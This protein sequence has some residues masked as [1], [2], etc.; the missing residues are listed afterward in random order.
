M[1][2]APAPLV[3]PEIRDPST[4]MTPRFNL[5]LRL[6]AR[7]FFGH[8]DIG[9]DDVAK[10]QKL[11]GAGAVV[12]VM[13][14]ASRLDYF[15]FNTLFAREGLRLSAFANGISFY[16]FQPLFGALRCALMRLGLRLGKGSKRAAERRRVREHARRVIAAGATMFLFLRPRRFSPLRR[17]RFAVEQGRGELDLLGEIVDAAGQSGQRVSLVPLALFWRRGPRSPARF[18]RQRYE[19]STRPSDLVKVITFLL[20]Y[21]R[22]AIKVG[23]PLEVAASNDPVGSEQQA[24]RL[25]RRMLLA[26]QDE[27]RSVEGPRLQPPSRVKQSVLSRARVRVAIAEDALQHGGSARANERAEKIFSEIAANMNPTFLALAGA[28]VGWVFRRLFVSIETRGLAD[29]RELVKRYPVVLVPSHRSYFDFLLVSWLLHRDYVPPP[30][31][32]AR[33]NM[34]FGPFGFLFRRA[35]AFFLRRSF[36]GELYKAVFRAYVGYLVEEGFPQEFFIEGGRSRTGKSRLPQ[37]GMLSWNIQG[38]VD[39]RRRE[40]YFVPISISY[41]RLVEEDALVSE[42][43]GGAKRDESML[44]LVRAR[45]LLK[46]RR[47]KVLVNFGEPLSLARELGGKRAL[48]DADQ[49]APARRAFVERFGNRIVERIN[50]AVVVNATSVAACALLGGAQRGFSRDEVLRRMSEVVEVLKLQD[51]R[52]TPTFEADVP[53][54][55]ESLDFLI[56]AGLLSKHAHPHGEVLHIGDAQWRTLDVHR[57][58]ILHYLAVPGWM[59]WRLQHFNSSNNTAASSREVLR[60]DLAF[61]LDLFYGELYVARGLALAAHFDALLAHLEA[62][63][64]LEVVESINGSGGGLRLNERGRARFG[65]LAEQMRGLLELYRAVFATLARLD[66]PTAQRELEAQVACEFQRALLLGEFQLAEAWT[67]AGV[68]TVFE[69]ACRRG[70]LERIASSG[71]SRERALQ[72]G[73]NAA[74]VPLCSARLAAALAHR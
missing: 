56:E 32:A 27:Q 22:L 9:D 50:Q 45:K 73:P 25:R 3:A 2:E 74:E 53:E 71:K 19:S 55:R 69:L 47:G 18:R 30:H 70:W 20:T 17:R 61:W 14:Y 38:F 34:A 37:L 33:E 64:A 11:E 29:L 13:R 72:A 35:G 46:R 44:G 51:V 28:V 10:L 15:L 49:D 39:S 21:R 5:L 60:A 65:F 7:R 57:N 23:A 59:L 26:L 36:D 42:L 41:E 1:V 12:Y 68:Q 62:V 66:G 63:G 54:F 16:Y 67:P 8:F 48:F 43:E 6:F 58:G 52:L 31:V 40:L 4:A 24:R